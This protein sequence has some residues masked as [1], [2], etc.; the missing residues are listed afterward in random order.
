MSHL[1]KPFTR[2]GAMAG[3]GWLGNL[4]QRHDGPKISMNQC[5]YHCLFNLVKSYHWL[6]IGSLPHIALKKKPEILR[7]GVETR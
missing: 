1:A 2:S 5:G 6:Q 7:G 4:E 3:T